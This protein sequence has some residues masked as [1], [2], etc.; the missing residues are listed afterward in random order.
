MAGHQV[1][2]NL[3]GVQLLPNVFVQ[4]AGLVAAHA[5]KA[6][7]QH[8]T[9]HRP[10]PAL[11]G[12]QPLEETAVPF[13]VLLERVQK[14]ALAETP[15]T[16]EEIVLASPNQP[17]GEAGIVHAV[18]A[19]LPNFPE[20]LDADWQS[21]IVR[22]ESHP[23]LVTRLD[24]R[25]RGALA[26]EIPAQGRDIP[27]G[28]ERTTD[29]TPEAG[30]GT[31]ASPPGGHIEPRP[32]QSC[33][34]PKRRRSRQR[35]CPSGCG[36]F[37]EPFGRK[38]S[39]ARSRVLVGGERRVPPS[40]LASHDC[41]PSCRCTVYISPYTLKCPCGPYPQGRSRSRTAGTG[42]RSPKRLVRKRSDWRRAVVWGP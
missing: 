3:K 9:P 4:I 30:I 27:G 13:E 29:R 24:S 14:Q 22:A 12:M 36:P 11:V 25:A 28:K 34:R 33:A 31:E 18:K 1:R 37:A 10:V 26:G 41:R 8:R 40:T 38:Q 20:R 21:A 6:K 32:T 35:M 5:C 39:G 16:R 7:A 17:Q 42:R 23:R 2:R 19:F 15:G